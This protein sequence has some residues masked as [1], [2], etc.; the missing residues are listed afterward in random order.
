MAIRVKHEHVFN[1]FV[2]IM[3]FLFA[4]ILSGCTPEQ[5]KDSPYYR[6]HKVS[7][8]KGDVCKLSK[9]L[10]NVIIDARL[11]G[12]QIE[13]VFE[14]VND[15]SINE[16]KLNKMNDMSDGAFTELV[17][18]L[19]ISVYE[20]P[21]ITNMSEIEKDNFLNHVYIECK[22]HLQNEI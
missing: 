12:K 8:E 3:L 14:E 18:E 4:F 10:A 1:F 19:V 15:L 11:R 5:T 21:M 22:R 13:R 6:I 16:P 20:Y 9:N 7:N 17:Q 2:S